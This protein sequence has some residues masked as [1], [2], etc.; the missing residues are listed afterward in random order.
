MKDYYGYEGKVAVITGAASGMG[1]AATEMLIDLGAKV[2]ALDRNEVTLPVE[3]AIK[4]NLLRKES[5]DVALAQLPEKV[6]FF[7]SCAGVPGPKYQGGS[8]TEA[9]VVVI[10]YLAPRYLTEKLIPRMGFGSAIAIISSA[11]GMGWQ[12]KIE[13]LA[14]LLELEGFEEG[15]NFLKEHADFPAV[16]PNGGYSNS[17]EAII[18]YAKARCDELSAKGIRINT[19]SPGTTYTPMTEDFVNNYGTGG[20]DA[21]VTQIGRGAKPEE[22]GEPLV[23]INSNMARYVSGVDLPVD[24]GFQGSTNVFEISLPEMEG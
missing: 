23:F 10:N 24:Y 3:K 21:I 20:S 15:V 14:P 19:L 17:K 2:F 13:E 7:F 12:S 5:M 11:A 22:M 4:V 1:A 6:D 9:D 16:L 8:F 18:I